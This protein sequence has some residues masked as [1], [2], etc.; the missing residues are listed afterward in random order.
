L[1]FFPTGIRSQRWRRAGWF[2]GGAF[3]LANVWLLIVATQLWA[4]P[5]TSTFSQAG[6]PAGAPVLD[7]MTAVLDQR[8]AAGQRGGG[9][10]QVRQVIG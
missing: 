9:R 10:G 7:L 8:R 3:T 2:I 4:H 1:L 6:S 5:F